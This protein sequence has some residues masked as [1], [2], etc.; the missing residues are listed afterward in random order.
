MQLPKAELAQAALGASMQLGFMAQ[1]NSREQRVK[2]QAQV[3][4]AH[5]VLNLYENH[6][7]VRL[8]RWWMKFRGYGRWPYAQ[9]KEAYDL[10]QTPID[11]RPG[12]APPFP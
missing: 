10:S 11:V 1:T 3:D 4:E 7:V 6:W 12:D 9:E 8:L 2:L 5:L